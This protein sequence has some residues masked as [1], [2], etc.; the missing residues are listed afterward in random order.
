[1]TPE[2]LLLGKLFWNFLAIKSL[3]FGEERNFC[4]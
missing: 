3:T 1:M 2:G 4:V